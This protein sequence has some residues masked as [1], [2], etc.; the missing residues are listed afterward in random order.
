MAM[1]G[2]IASA[3]RRPAQAVRNRFGRSGG[4]QDQ[5]RRRRAVAVS[6]RLGRDLYELTKPSSAAVTARQGLSRRSQGAACPGF[7]HKFA[8]PTTG[9][10]QDAM[11]MRPPQLIR[12]ADHGPHQ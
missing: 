4:R 2:G 11:R 9:P 8:P 10:R 6:G 7:P 1:V 3:G 12:T 5:G